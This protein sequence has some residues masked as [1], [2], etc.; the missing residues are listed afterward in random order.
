[1]KTQQFTIR[2]LTAL[3]LALASLLTSR[4]SAQTAP[5]AAAI[6]P[7]PDGILQLDAS[8]AT[9]HGQTARFEVLDGLGN[10]CYWSN[11]ADWISW[12]AAPDR[13]GE[14]VVE[15]KFSCQAGSQGSTF[16]VSLGDQKFSSRIAADTGTW[17]DHEIMKL[18]SLKVVQPGPQTLAL[19]PSRNP[20]Q[21]VMNLAWLRLIP[22]SQYA[23]YL[24]KTA[25]EHQT[26]AT[27]VARA[28]FVVPNFHPASCGW[29]TDW[30]TERN[31]CAYSYLT[32]LDRVRDDP[33]YG[34]ALSEVNNIMAIREFEPERFKELQQRVREGRVELCNAFFLEPTINLSGGEALVK[35]GVEGLRWQQQVMGVRPRICWAIDVTGLHE[36]MAQIVAG[37]GLDALVYSRDNPTSSTLHWQ[38][39]P[40]GTRTLALSPGHYSDFGALFATKEPLSQVQLRGLAA[41]LRSKARHTPASAPLLVLG[42]SGDYALAPARKEYPTGFLQQWKEFAPEAEVQFTGPSRYLDAVLPLIKSGQLQ[43]PTSKS[44]AR[45]TWSSF[46]IQCPTVKQ[47]YRESEQQLQ[48]AEALSAIASLKSAFAYPVQP[49]YDAWLL[50]CLNMDRNTL[51]GA[52]GGMVFEHPTSWDVRDRFNKV[53]SIAADHSTEALRSLLGDGQALGL[54]N[55]LNWQR[56]D[57]VR[58]KLPANSRPAGV[59]CQADADG[60]TLCKVDLAPL[61]A[62]GAEL[63]PQP[64]VAAAQID[65]PPAL[66]TEHYTAKLD[67]ASG[68]L[69]S[70]KLKPSGREVLGGPV[71]LV[72]EKGG[73]GHDTPRRPKR[74]RLADSAQFK[75]VIRVSRGSLATVVEARS[76][77]QGGGEL[78][79]TLHFYPDSPRIDFDVECEDIPNQNVVV[80]EFPLARD[81]SATRRGIP[82]GFSQGAW[83]VPNTNLSGFAD[84]ILA[85]IRWSHYEFVGGGGVA[86]LDRGLPGRE[87]TGRTPV[88]FLLN[89]QDTYLGYR[90]A[91]LSG[92]GKH[93]G[94]F[95][96][97]AHDGDWLEA[98]IPQMAWEFNC[99]PIL[100]SDVKTAAPAS[101]AETSD[102]VI[103]EALRRD[104]AFIEMRLAECFGVSGTARVTLSLPH[105]EAALTD[106]VGQHASPLAG[107]PTYEFPVRPQQIVTLR[108]KTAQSVAEI[109]PRLKWDELVPEAKLSALMKKLPGRVGHPPLGTEGK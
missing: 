96:L 10:I 74:Q 91:W 46:W 11:P 25:A 42:G 15:L 5:P 93:H 37:L 9:I 8:A 7:Q 4:A 32:H 28:V 23:G 103:V 109:Q 79:Q 100:T 97:V 90:C 19:K 52:A 6:Q 78:R 29:L 107:G 31:Y 86:L 60:L 101:F 26:G 63:T 98:R 12:Q 77:F 1:M 16:D 41:N 58:L 17:Y 45:L 30:S 40:D 102:N 92:K 81:I 68:A 3:L 61:S 34:F 104:G 84:G 65:L 14:F 73:D 55:P 39:S 83:S 54:F 89:A 48:A 13:A 99:P 18:G 57:P 71:L 51:W 80:A 87:L 59:A 76:K 21:A 49:L 53:E 35:M 62:T 108:F 2:R 66:E 70:L 24:A 50:M 95:A 106:L 36:Q 20:G 85:A 67:P 47:T 27:N 88:L 56:H 105:A 33:N 72:A 38:E 82:Y 69:M 44:G 64:P 94:S 75:P 43:L 22:E